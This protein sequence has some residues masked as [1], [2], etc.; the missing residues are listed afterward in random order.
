VKGTIHRVLF[1]LLACALQGCPEA[2]PVVDAG[3]E[4]DASPEDAADEAL[5]GETDDDGEAA[6]LDLPDHDPATSLVLVVPEGAALCPAFRECVGCWPDELAGRA[7]LSLRAGSHVLERAEGT[8]ELAEGL[9]E[10][11]A[12]G[13]EG[14]PAAP[15]AYPE[16]RTAEHLAG[17]GW[18]QWSFR[19]T[20]AF[21]LDGETLTATAEVRLTRL[22]AEQPAWPEAIAADATFRQFAFLGGLERAASGQ[23]LVSCDPPAGGVITVEAAAGDGARLEVSTCPA[24]GCSGNTSCLVLDRAELTL[25]GVTRLVADPLRLAYSAEHHNF[26]QRYAVGLA[27]PLGGAAIALLEEPD[28]WSGTPGQLVLLDEAQVELSRQPCVTWEETSP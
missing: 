7:R 11:L 9:V 3:W 5:D 22:E 17:A 4:E 10:G 14:R 16:E 26:A 19:F 12:V 25:G 2:R 15:L 18:E 1:T 20:R 27:P 21:T 28:T 13:P 24:C 23:A 8:V 6:D